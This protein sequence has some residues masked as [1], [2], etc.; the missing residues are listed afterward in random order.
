MANPRQRRKSR[1]SSYKAVSQSRRAAKNL[2]KA[3][4]IRG[5]KALQEAW[6]KHKT[7]KQNYA[8]LGLI[9]DLNPS[10]PGGSDKILVPRYGEEEMA[11][12][13]P[14]EASSTSK[15]V[16]PR[17]HGRII[18]DE[19][20]NVIGIELNEEDEEEDAESDMEAEQTMEDL[21]AAVD[22]SV[23]GKWATSLGQ[24][25][26]VAGEKTAGL[27][28]ELESIASK[29]HL[30]STTLSLA[31][32]STGPNVRHAATGEIVYLSKLVAKHRD[33]VEAM[34]KDR[35]L[36]PDQRTEGQLRRALRNAG[37]WGK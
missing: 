9:H 2:K 5:P 25:N 6:D 26:E 8:R 32:S 10:A 3:P 24:Q 28:E 19:S 37:L 16:V 20:G 13:T 30:D 23:M 18:R 27:L 14:K 1:S 12:D 31:Q 36:N 21:A 29:K 15:A 17:G 33:D 22:D 4:P 35:R 7:V 34:A 11:V